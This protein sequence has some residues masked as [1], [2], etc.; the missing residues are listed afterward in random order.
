MSSYAFLTDQG[1]LIVDPAWDAAAIDRLERAAGPMLVVVS[2]Q[3]HIRD[4]RR[5]QDRLAAPIAASGRAAHDLSGIN[6][7]LSGDETLPG[8]W[9]VLEAP[10]VYAGE[11]AL[12]RPAGGGVLYVGDL[13]VTQPLGAAAG[14]PAAT[15]LPERL[16][17]D[18]RRLQETL[19]RLTELPFETV[20]AGHGPP[21][22][23]GGRNRVRALALGRSTGQ[24]G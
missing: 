3:S 8:E 23:T 15:L 14:Q 2:T 19:G 10:G 7:S 12:Y 18:P 9:R 22:L 11:I 21:I 24:E 6:R 5:F 1:G 20:L 16:R 17:S 4:A 13:F